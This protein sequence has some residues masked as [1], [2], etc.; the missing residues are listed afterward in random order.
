VQVR[1][2]Q[3]VDGEVNIGVSAHGLTVY[4][5]QLNIYRWPWQKIIQFS[6]N[7][8]GFTVKIRPQVR[9]GVRYTELAVLQYMSVLCVCVFCICVCVVQKRLCVYMSICIF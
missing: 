2:A 9:Q 1:N 4:K 3:D 7:R 6:Y 8:G 5:D